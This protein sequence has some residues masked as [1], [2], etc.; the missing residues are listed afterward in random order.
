LIDPQSRQPL[1]IRDADGKTV[2]AKVYIQEIYSVGSA[3]SD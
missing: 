1:K 3:P 2:T